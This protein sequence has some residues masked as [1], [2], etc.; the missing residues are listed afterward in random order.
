MSSG[1]NTS[2]APDDEADAD[3]PESKEDFD[4][5]KTW[6]AGQDNPQESAPAVPVEATACKLCKATGGCNL[7]ALVWHNLHLMVGH[8]MATQ[9]L[10][11]IC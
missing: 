5:F 8:H 2:D 7:S 6:L 4:D 3:D 11:V 10:D 9:T 1:A